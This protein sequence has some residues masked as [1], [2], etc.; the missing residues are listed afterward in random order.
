MTIVYKIKGKPDLHFAT[1]VKKEQTG[2]WEENGKKEMKVEGVL[3]WIYLQENE[4]KD[5][6]T[7]R[8][9]KINIEKEDG[10]KVYIDS[11]VSTTVGRNLINSLTSLSKD[12]I[13][14]PINVSLYT[15]Q[16]E[17]N[18]ETYTN[19][20]IAVRIDWELIKWAT[21][22]ADLPKPNVVKF[23][24]KNMKDYTEQLEALVKAFKEVWGK[25]ENKWWEDVDV[26]DLPF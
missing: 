15:T 14:K 19:N 11:S 9:L 12:D 1:L 6:W 18:W 5:Y 21:N 13:D 25:E 7:I 17:Y 8:T 16:R 10:E 23:Q 3:K 22:P 26:S 4:T 24:G 2:N 20:N